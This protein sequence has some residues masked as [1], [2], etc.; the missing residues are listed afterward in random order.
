MKRIG[1]LWVMSIFA[2]CFGCSKNEIESSKSE[3]NII[4][5]WVETYPELFDGVSDT[6]VFAK[7][8]LINGH[9]YFNGWNY[10]VNRDSISF[11]KDGKRM[12]FLYSVTDEDNIVIYDFLDRLITSQ[13]KNIHFTKE[14]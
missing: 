3:T 5:V 12:S 13:V 9:F 2:T 10:L 8:S 6:I 14:K 7:D 4:G 1:L 11:S